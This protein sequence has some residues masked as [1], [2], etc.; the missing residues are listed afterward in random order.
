MLAFDITPGH[1][2]RR[3]GL[4]ALALQDQRP[5]HRPGH[6]NRTGNLVQHIAGAGLAQ[7]MHGQD[8]DVVGVGQVFERA[9][10]LVIA[11]VLRSAALS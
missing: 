8:R 9:E 2:Q 11:L 5:V 10:C 6:A 1:K 4:P 7:V 3:L